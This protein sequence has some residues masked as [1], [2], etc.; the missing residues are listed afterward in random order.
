MP[1]RSKRKAGR[2]PKPRGTVVSV[3][4]I[5]HQP[6]DPYDII[7][8]RGRKMLR[9]VGGKRGPGERAKHRL[10]IEIKEEVKATVR[11]KPRFF[12]VLDQPNRFVELDVAEWEELGFDCTG[13]NSKG[14]VHAWNHQCDVFIAEAAKKVTPRV[15]EG[16]D[17]FSIDI[18]KYRERSG[19][20]KKKRV[21]D[22]LDQVSPSHR[23]VLKAYRRW[24]KHEN[25]ERKVIP[26]RIVYRDTE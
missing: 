4:V 7:F 3:R 17:V 8:R 22:P 18:R 25:G 5:L 14:T 21:I 13:L 20:S 23:V 16:R 19:K 12:C 9:L 15:V 2:I 1:V 11:R 26:G 10:R 6:D 24:L